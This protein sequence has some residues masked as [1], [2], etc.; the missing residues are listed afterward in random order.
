VIWEGLDLACGGVDH[1]GELLRAVP[2]DG[3]ARMERF[4]CEHITTSLVDA[5]E[6]RY[7]LVLVCGVIGI[8]RSHLKLR[9]VRD[10]ED[11]AGQRLFFACWVDN[12]LAIQDSKCCAVYGVLQL[13]WRRLSIFVQHAR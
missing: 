9:V 10:A 12:D 3:H 1:G 5:C 7:I 8:A 2:G 4:G 11:A 13:Q 6:L